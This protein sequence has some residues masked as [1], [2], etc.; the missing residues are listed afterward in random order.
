M[1]AIK[2]SSVIFVDKGESNKLSNS[3]EVQGSGINLVAKIHFKATV[4][5]QFGVQ[6]SIMTLFLEV[7]TGVDR[8]HEL[9]FDPL[10]VARAGFP[11]RFWHSEFLRGFG[12][13]CCFLWVGIK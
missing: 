2:Q 11:V 3:F 9:N 5:H 7:T 6:Q 4:C 8:F 13:I 12:E 1:A 10:Q